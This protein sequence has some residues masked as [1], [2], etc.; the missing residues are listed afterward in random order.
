MYATVGTTTTDGPTL[1]M[2]IR[3]HRPLAFEKVQD[4]SG[5][6]SMRTHYSSA[7]STLI[8][9]LVCNGLVGWR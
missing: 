9:F 6:D 3:W 5:G 4:A 8:L 1:A 7:R 2:Q